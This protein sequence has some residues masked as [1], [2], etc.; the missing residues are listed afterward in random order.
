M[1]VKV[2]FFASCRE[3]VGERQAEIELSDG[4]TVSDLVDRIAS[5]H[6]R[7]G[8]VAKTAMVSVNQEYVEPSHGLSEGDEV[9]VIPPVSGGR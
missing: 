1:K 3:I 9:A 4:A 8:D 7:F 2:L 5:E 6:P